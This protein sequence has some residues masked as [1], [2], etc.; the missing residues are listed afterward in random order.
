MATN[1]VEAFYLGVKADIDP[2]EGNWQSEN[3]GTLVGQVF[4]SAG[5]PLHT[6]IQNLTLNDTNND[7]AVSENDYGRAAEN[8]T[9][10]AVNSALDSVA[11]YNV[12]LTYS[13]GSTANT[14]MVLLQDVSGRTFLAPHQVGHSQNAVLDDKPIASISLTSVSSDYYSGVVL[15]LEKNAFIDGLVQGTGGNDNIGTSYTDADGTK[16][17]AYGGNDTVDAG[18]G[19]D[20]ISAGVG[21]DVIYSGVG[22]DSVFGGSGNDSIFGGDGN[23][24]INGD[25]GSDTIFGGAGADT[26]DGGTG[27]DRIDGGDGNDVIKL[28]D[29]FGADTITGGEGGTDF[30]TL[31]LSG[32]TG[33]VSVTYTGSDGESGTVTSG[34]D[35]AAFSGVEKLVFTGQADTINASAVRTGMN[36]DAGGGAD[37]VT[38][39]SGD[40]T[41]LGAAGADRLSGS[42]GR[43]QIFGGDGNDT[44]F[45][46]TGADTLRGGLG[47]DN[48]S[49]GDGADRFDYSVGDGA[50]T[51]SDFN[52]G[53][54]GT[55]SDGDST[56]ND[57]LDLSAFYDNLSELY[58]DQADDGILNQSNTTDA[59]GRAT[60]YSDNQK[61][62]SGSILVQGASADSSSFTVE[63]TGVVCFTAGTAILTPGGEVL[64][65]DLRI[66]DLVTTMD[67]GPQPIR[68]IG[69][70]SIGLPLLQALPNLRPVLIKKGV[71]GARRDLLVSQ[72]H[73]MLIG[74][75]GSQL[76]RA[77]HLAGHFPGVR[78]A[79]GKRQITYVHLMFDAH[80]I[81]FAENTPS[82]SFYPG[83]MAIR[84]M[85]TAQR[86]EMGVL[87]P[88]LSRLFGPAGE[89]SNPYGQTARE[90]LA[91][92]QM[93]LL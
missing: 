18:A 25:A 4:G 33:G 26:I 14:T 69:K 15:N 88:Q 64:I 21:D 5:A 45:G 13:D 38:G 2:N 28:T 46:G 79:Q 83:P 30:D 34:A 92:R 10:G 90:F 1:T 20:T 59:K 57:F 66:G 76:G 39:G 36:I 23:D 55:L 40:D 80:Q 56:N 77:K 93:T 68:W 17:N 84:L 41:I 19:N 85:G 35:T 7:G 81:I 11:I 8:L 65:E 16:M 63:N 42:G 52:S 32:L 67:N 48:L 74:K 75:G 58:A 61:F 31:D 24:V 53:N 3:A 89:K 62:G 22:A 54:S 49:G 82:E 9:F 43:D 91:E 51:I 47:N 78:I 37:V 71:L 50:D 6:N 70:R 44:I 73:G 27:S 29:S 12:K 60:D 72:Q 87:F 86:A